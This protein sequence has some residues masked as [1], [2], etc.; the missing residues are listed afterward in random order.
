MEWFLK[1]LT[2]Y[3]DFSGRARRTE[4]LMFT[5]V[6][7][8]LTII[9][10]ILDNI[11]FSDLFLNQTE[12]YGPLTITFLLFTAIPSLSVTVRRLHDTGRSGFWYF[13]GFVPLVGG[14]ILLF[15]LL[16]DSERRR[17]RWGPNPKSQIV[18]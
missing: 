17:N 8:A 12:G 14:L 10:L 9:L 16:Q 18:Y 11:L 13:V 7:I 5:L 4:F 1:A 15:I 6:Q 2:Q 3:F